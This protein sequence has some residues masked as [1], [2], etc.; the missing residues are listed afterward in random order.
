MLEFEVSDQ[1]YRAAPMDALTQF[2][3][4]R[5]LSPV[6]G[7]MQDFAAKASRE[8]GLIDA[9]EPVALVVSRIP[10]QDVEYI[11][12]ACLTTVQR[13][14]E[15]D[16][17]WTPVWSTG[18]KRPLFD[19]IAMVEMLTITGHVVMGALGNFTVGPLSKLSGAGRP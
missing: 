11:L 17:G 19:D 4:A 9:L 10:D 18:A 8:G 12:N 6:L 14:Q 2:H 1:T 13:K 7:A 5:R 15:G 3:V 16:R